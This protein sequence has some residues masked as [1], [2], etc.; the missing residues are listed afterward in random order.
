MG[1]GLAA[2]SGA[3]RVAGNQT[4]GRAPDH[5]E[6][7]TMGRMQAPVPSSPAPI[8]VGIGGWQYAPWRGSFYP[9][10]LPQKEELAHASRQLSLIE[11]NSSYYRTPSRSSF[12]AWQAATPPGF[13]FSIKAPRSIVQQ[14]MLRHTEVAVTEFLQSGLAEMG[15]KLGPIVWQFGP[16]KS[17]DPEDLPGFLA[18]LPR[19]LDG[20]PLRH[21]L[22]VRH[23]SFLNP[24]FLALIREHGVSVVGTDSDEHPS[25][26][27]VSGELVYLRLMRGLSEEPAGY[28]P[29]ALADWQQHAHRWA[30]GEEPAGLPR[31]EGAP[32]AAAMARP[33][34]VLFINGAKE[35]APAAA[36]ALLQRLHPA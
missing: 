5:T 9:K 11:I 36:Q 13:V 18:L 32:P 28:S 7:I 34:Y 22:E 30:S 21:V 24:A 29:Q 3:A 26:F 8:L 35:R 1:I 12:T 20:L 10:G 14:R 2:A 15:D 23:A 31:I 16:Y 4:G 25:F 27:D 19:T 33:V 6:S 17:F